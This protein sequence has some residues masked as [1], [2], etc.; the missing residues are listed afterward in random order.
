MIN[1]GTPVETTILELAEMIRDRLGSN[2]AVEFIDYESYY[3]A[4]FEDTRRRVPDV[5][6]ARDVLGWEPTVPLEEGLDRTLEWWERQH[7]LP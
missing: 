1:L 6:R 3:G 2:S 7:P 5:S 4:G